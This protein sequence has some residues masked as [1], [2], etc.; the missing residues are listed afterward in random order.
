MATVEQPQS[1]LSREGRGSGLFERADN[2]RSDARLIKQMLTLGVVSTDEV[3]D[4]LKK[5][6]ELAANAKNSRVYT[7]VMKVLLAAAKLEQSERQ[8]AQPASA[9]TNIQINGDVRL[10]NPDERRT[11]LLDIIAAASERA[12]EA[13]SRGTINAPAEPQ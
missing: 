5:G 4:L 12:R 11:E 1:E 8:V 10:S 13:E 9:T 7:A 6:F 2:F 3:H